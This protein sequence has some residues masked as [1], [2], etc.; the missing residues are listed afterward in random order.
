MPNTRTSASRSESASP[1]PTMLARAQTGPGDW[2]ALALEH[3][4]QIRAAFNTARKALPGGARISAMKGLAIVLN[5]HS[6]AEEVVLYPALAT[7]ADAEHAEEAYDE[8]S[9]A[10]IQMAQLERLDPSTAAWLEKLEEIVEAVSA[11]M[12]N[13]ESSWFLAIKANY[14]DQAKLTAR[15]KEEFERYTRTGIV[16]TNC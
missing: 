14:P 13:E 8:Q 7:L 6:L 5:G 9:E 15:F 11:H 3:H 12:E 4:D 2:L 1:D 16:A 10:K